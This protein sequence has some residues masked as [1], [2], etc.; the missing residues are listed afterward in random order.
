[1]EGMA[2]P[3]EV[4]KLRRVASAGPG[5]LPGA[6][7]GAAFGT[8]PGARCSVASRNHCDDRGIGISASFNRILTNGSTTAWAVKAALL[9]QAWL[10][11]LRTLYL[12]PVVDTPMGISYL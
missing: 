4:V 7:R 2:S 8:F 3:E 9:I 12:E 11:D 10:E 6:A 5:C 1:M